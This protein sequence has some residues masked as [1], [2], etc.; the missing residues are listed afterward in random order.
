[1]SSETIESTTAL[2]L[3][4]FFHGLYKFRKI[5]HGGKSP[6][7]LICHPDDKIILIN[8]VRRYHDMPP[9]DDKSKI[10]F[11]VVHDVRMIGSEDVDPLKWYFV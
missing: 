2:S 10:K 3:E 9:I 8:N 6:T 5:S 1:M 7:V 4:A 11:M